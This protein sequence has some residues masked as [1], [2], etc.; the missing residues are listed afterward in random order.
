MEIFVLHS[1]RHRDRPKTLSELCLVLDIEDT[2]IANYAVKKL[3]GIGLVKTGRVGKEKKIE[4]TD[5][6]AEVIARYIDI[7]EQILVDA[8]TVF[9]L[10]QEEISDIAAHLRAFS[11]YYEQAARAAA[12]L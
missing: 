2:H 9:G 5:K 11:G 4:I 10:P 7:R 12:T 1:V 6:G 3:A 8:M